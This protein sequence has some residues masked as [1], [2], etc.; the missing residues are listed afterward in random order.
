MQRS[1]SGKHYKSAKHSDTSITLYHL[2]E[3][4]VY[5]KYILQNRFYFLKKSFHSILQGVAQSKYSFTADSLEELR[6]L[7]QGWC[8]AAVLGSFHHLHMEK[9]VLLDSLKDQ[10]FFPEPQ[11][12]ALRNRHFQHWWH[13]RTR[14]CILSSST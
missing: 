6:L 3:G 12:A 5:N 1:S 8:E 4:S 13:M 10:L 2:V 7:L 11:P 14:T 9:I